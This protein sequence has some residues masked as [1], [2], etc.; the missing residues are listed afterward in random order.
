MQ[1]RSLVQGR[2]KGMASISLEGFSVAF[3]ALVAAAAGT[4]T[5][6]NSEGLPWGGLALSWPGLP[7]RL[8]AEYLAILCCHAVLVSICFGEAVFLLVHLRTSP[9]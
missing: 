3:T 6:V 5:S 4:P 8:R 2:C 7:A 9:V 1:A